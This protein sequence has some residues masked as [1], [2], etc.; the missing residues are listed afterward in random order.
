M[1]PDEMRGLEVGIVGRWLRGERQEYHNK[2]I[3]PPPGFSGFGL[4]TLRG[5][6]SNG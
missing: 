1:L 3:T 6:H 2:V 4:A 5:L